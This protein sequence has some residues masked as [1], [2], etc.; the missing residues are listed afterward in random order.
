M[1]EF[2]NGLLE[3]EVEEIEIKN[4]NLGF[5]TKPPEV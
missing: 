4:G 2:S 3:G 1:V 5:D